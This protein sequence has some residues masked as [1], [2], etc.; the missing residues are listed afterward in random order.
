[1]SNFGSFVTFFLNDEG[2]MEESTGCLIVLFVVIV[3][4]G[5]RR[6]NQARLKMYVYRKLNSL[7]P[8]SGL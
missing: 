7:E 1:M 6:T 3:I 2:T 4:C 8:V 5:W